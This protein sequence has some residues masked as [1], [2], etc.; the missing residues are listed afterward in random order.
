MC[1]RHRHD[2]G[3]HPKA[4]SLCERAERDFRIIAECCV[5]SKQS[6]TAVTAHP[7]PEYSKLTVPTARPLTLRLPRPSGSS[8]LRSGPCPPSAPP[9]SGH[10]P[11]SEGGGH[12]RDPGALPP[13]KRGWASF[14]GCKSCLSQRAPHQRPTLGPAQPWEDG[15]LP[16]SPGGAWGGCWGPAP[17]DPLRSGAPTRPSA[18]ARSPGI[19]SGWRGGVTTKI[20]AHFAMKS[21]RPLAPSPSNWVTRSP[22]W[23]FVFDLCNKEFRGSAR[24]SLGDLQVTS[25]GE[26]V[27]TT[28][29]NPHRGT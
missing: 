14:P 11:C 23:S 22:S 12:G 21:A 13:R 16:K 3:G 26:G 9:W 8:L 18:A 24:C 15:V 20:G 29:Q 19:C 27:E 6:P 28:P 25:S 10:R 5:C 2:R 7:D 4:T 17:R 1:H